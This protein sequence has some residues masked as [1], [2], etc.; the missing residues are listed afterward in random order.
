MN[1][2]DAAFYIKIQ[3]VI[4]RIFPCFLFYY[5]EE[6]FVLDI[7]NSSWSIELQSFNLHMVQINGG[8]TLYFAKKFVKHFTFI[9]NGM[10]ICY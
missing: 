5:I 1:Y 8:R 7:L 2:L 9:R 6:L 10:N 3:V 4:L